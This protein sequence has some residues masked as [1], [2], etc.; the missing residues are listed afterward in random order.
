MAKI[1]IFKTNRKV[2]KSAYLTACEKERGLLGS[3]ELTHH[4]NVDEIIDDSAY[5]VD[6]GS[7]L[8]R[9]SGYMVGGEWDAIVRELQ[10]PGMFDKLADYFR[11][12]RTK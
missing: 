5:T 7:N 8:K 9:A 3:V 10:R 4:S 12:G 11:E 1:R 6:P 2:P